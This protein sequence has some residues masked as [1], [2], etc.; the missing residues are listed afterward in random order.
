[1]SYPMMIWNADHPEAEVQCASNVLAEIGDLA[2]S[3]YRR[4]AW[5]GVE[6]GGVLCGKIE[7][8]MIR[9]CSMR[10][11]ECEHH[12]GPE[13]HLSENFCKALEHLLAGAASDQSLAGLTPVGWYHSTS[14]RDLSLSDHARGLFHR[15]FPDPCQIALLVQRSKR[16]PLSLALFVRDSRGRVELHSPAREF[17]LESSEYPRSAAATAE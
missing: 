11:A 15:F 7:P 16:D 8:G 13:F 10:L 12:Y 5:G 17:T 2:L 14:R 9:V 4:Y 3:G 1:M 6:I